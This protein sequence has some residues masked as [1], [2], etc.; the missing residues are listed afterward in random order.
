MYTTI[1]CI[2]LQGF[3]D[4]AQNNNIGFKYT[5]LKD[6]IDKIKIK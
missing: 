2:Y 3:P 5:L 4:H 1:P 6:N